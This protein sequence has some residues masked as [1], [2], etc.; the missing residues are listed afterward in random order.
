MTIKRSSIFF[1]ILV[2]SLSVLVFFSSGLLTESLPEKSKPQVIC[3]RVDDVQDFAFH[4]GQMR[5]FTIAKEHRIPFS[6]SLISKYFSAD[7]NLISNISEAIQKGSEVTVHGWS[8]EE[9]TSLSYEEQVQELHLAKENINRLLRV[10]VTVLVPPLFT[11]DNDTMRA[12]NDA[13]YNVLSSCLLYQFP[14]VSLSGIVNVP[15]TVD[16]S[17]YENGTWMAKSL[18]QLLGEINRSVEENGYAM[19]VIHP[20]ELMSGDTVNENAAKLFEDLVVNLGENY[21]YCT[22]SDIAEVLS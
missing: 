2:L 20:Q 7:W 16:F 5:I 13:G 4:E 10:K 17:D 1:L 22:I 11:Y 6:Y 19:L 14:G 15:G 8:H 9:L 12:M 18:S 3:I 21:S